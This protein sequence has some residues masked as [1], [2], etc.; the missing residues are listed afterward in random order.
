[1]ARVGTPGDIQVTQPNSAHPKG[2]HA[3]KPEPE[4]SRL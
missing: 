2:T 1:M 4:L 3:D